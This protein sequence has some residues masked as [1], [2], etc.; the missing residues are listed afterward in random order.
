[1]SYKLKDTDSKL[2]KIQTHIL[3]QFILVMTLK[4][5]TLSK[6]EQ[7]KLAIKL[8]HNNVLELL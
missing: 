7:K 3:S 8:Y 1:M 6:C 2:N 5:E 4:N